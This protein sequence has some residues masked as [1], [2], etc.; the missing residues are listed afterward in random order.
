MGA[1]RYLE[2]SH[3][4]VMQK[5]ITGITHGLCPGNIQATSHADMTVRV[6]RVGNIGC[7]THLSAAK[8]LLFNLTLSPGLTLC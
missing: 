8:C 6:T 3:L 7:E 2:D 5:V 4:H 1:L